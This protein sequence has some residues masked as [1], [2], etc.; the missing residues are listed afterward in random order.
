MK[1]IWFILLTT[2]ILILAIIT[3]V[4]LVQDR[5]ALRGQEEWSKADRAYQWMVAGQRTN[6]KFFVFHTSLLPSLER[7]E[8]CFVYAEG[9][10]RA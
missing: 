10:P 2:I 7:T 1:K 4:P 6:R 9:L 3:L 5:A 8:D